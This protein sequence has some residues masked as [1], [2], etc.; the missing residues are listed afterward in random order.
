MPLPNVDEWM[1]SLSALQI[2]PPPKNPQHASDKS[3]RPRKEPAVPPLPAAYCEQRDDVPTNGRCS[4]KKEREDITSPA[5]PKTTPKKRR[6]T[7]TSRKRGEEISLPATNIST[8]STP[9]RSA[10]PNS[11]SNK[12]KT[13]SE[14][15]KQKSMKKISDL[16]SSNTKQYDNM[17]MIGTQRVYPR[18]L[19]QPTIYH[20]AATDLWIATIYTDAN[21]IPTA[22]DISTDTNL[23]KQGQKAFSFHDEKAARASAYANSLPV[24]IPYG[25]TSQCM[26]CDTSFT[27]LRRPKHCKNCGI[28]ICGD[29]STRWNT[30]M[31]PETYTSKSSTL[32]LSKT[33]RVCV[34]CDSV[35]KRFKSALMMGRYDMAVEVSSILYNCLFITAILISFAT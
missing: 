26:L 16:L 18:T 30:K 23:K 17:I 22:S 1:T 35:T 33:V 13:V 29:C 12:Q 20:N 15:N 14:N 27:F 8:S 2:V 5:A 10:T 19:V 4:S 31:L 3:L 32:G 28:I 6:Q 21:S 34:S 9:P 7:S 25:T 24:L 11:D